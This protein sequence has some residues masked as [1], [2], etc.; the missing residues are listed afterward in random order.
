MAR[1]RDWRFLCAVPVP[2]NPLDLTQSVGKAGCSQKQQAAFV[3]TSIPS[4]AASNNPVSSDQ[5]PPYPGAYWVLP[6]QLLAGPYPIPA[7]ASAEES[8][9]VLNA[10]LDAGIRSIID[11]MPQEE[12]NDHEQGELYAHYEDRMET[13][14]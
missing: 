11:L 13:L 9:A 3:A 14:A 8:D 7:H 5:R 2:G 4:P 6:G 10:L 1:R 12:I